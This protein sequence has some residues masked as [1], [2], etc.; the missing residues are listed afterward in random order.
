MG[1]NED[2]MGEMAEDLLD[3]DGGLAI[4]ATYHPDGGVDAEVAIILGDLVTQEENINN[5]LA[6]VTRGQARIAK[7]TM[8]RKDS[9][10]IDGVLYQVERF[11]AEGQMMVFNL[12]HVEMIERSQRQ[13]RERM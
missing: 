8:S 9:V 5:G 4:E 10:T 6:N 3:I 1:A 7:R 2:I 12:V 13:Y 11:E